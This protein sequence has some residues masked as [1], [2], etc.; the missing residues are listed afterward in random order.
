MGHLHPEFR[1]HLHRQ[2]AEGTTVSFTCSRDVSLKDVGSP[3]ADSAG[4]QTIGKF[5]NAANQS[6][7]AWL[8]LNFT[9]S[10]ADVSGL[11]ESDLKVWR[12]SG[13]V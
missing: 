10:D 13:T 1:L 8:S 3:A 9:Y 5:I 12:H 6:A 7:D 2:H 11:A 4:Q